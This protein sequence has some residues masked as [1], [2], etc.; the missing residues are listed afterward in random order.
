MYYLVLIRDTGVK[1]GDLSYE[2]EVPDIP[3]ITATGS[4]EKEAYDRIVSS[5]ILYFKNLKPG[6]IAPSASRSKQLIQATDYD[7]KI[8]WIEL[9]ECSSDE[10]PCRYRRPGNYCDNSNAVYLKCPWITT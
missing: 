8:A 10:M 9:P 1:Y 4:S 2:A 3:E 5:V 6:M 7:S